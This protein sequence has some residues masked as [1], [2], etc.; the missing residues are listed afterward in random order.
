MENFSFDRM[1]SINVLDAAQR[2]MDELQKEYS[3]M[4]T[5]NVVVVGK[6]GSGKSTL[7][8]H[9][10]REKMADTG[11]GMPVT[12]EIKKIEKAG[13]PLRIYD[14]PG[15]ELGGDN[16]I[17]NLIEDIQ[18]LIEDGIQSQDPNQAIHCIWYCINV[19]SSRIEPTEM[20][21][22]KNLVNKTKYYN[23]PVIVILTQAYPK[24]K[25]TE[26]KD[27]ILSAHLPI[28]AIVPVLAKD[29]EFD[30]DY[31]IK[32]SGLDKLVEVMNYVLPTRAKD[33]FV[34]IQTASLDLKKKKAQ[35]IVKL[36]AAA[37][38]AVGAIPIPFSDA[39]ILVPTQLSMLAK[40]TSSF[41]VSMQKAAMV[42]AITATIGT[43]GTTALGKSAVTNIL[44]LIPGAG[45]IAGG[46]ISGTTAADLT[47]ALGDAYIAIMVKVE[48]GEMNIAD[49]ATSKGQQELKREFEKHM[50]IRRDDMGEATV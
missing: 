29:V 44:K 3:S 50:R 15:L 20:E 9:V 48:K 41:G 16:S 21:F 5:I 45:M 31:V 46:A 40:I 7:I 36:A 42:G 22:I 26:M 13:F 33:T 14:T 17:E 10:F 11:T 39:A 23:V 38:A 34:A 30:D 25:I 18:G 2:L 43:T 37:A 12:Q 49:L 28:E 6:T 47:A 4:T 32:A 1:D 19:Q 27:A 24:K 35:T 8:N